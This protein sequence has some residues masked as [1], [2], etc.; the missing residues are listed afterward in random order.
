MP[1]QRFFVTLLALVALLLPRLAWAATYSATPEPYN[2]L[3]TSGHS[4][5]KWGGGC[6]GAFASVDDDI[7]AE[8]PLGF[9]FTFG[10]MNYTTARIMSNGRLQFGNTYCGNG[11]AVTSPRSYPLDLPNANLVRT[12]RIYGADFD[13]A[14]G[15]SITYKSIGSA[16]NRQ[17]V[18]SWTNI[19]EWGVSGS[20]F[21]LQIILNEN[22]DFVYQFGAATNTSGGKAQIGWQLSTTDYAVHA[23][24]TI[25]GLANTALRWGV[26]RSELSGTVFEDVNYGGGAG[27]S[28][29]AS[30]GAVAGNATVELY[31]S[32]GKFIAATST[33]SKGAFRFPVTSAGTY[34]VRVASTTVRSTRSGS[35]NAVGVLTYRTT[36]LS[37]IAV[38]Q[39]D[40]VGG[41]NPAAQD[42]GTASSGAT[43]NTSTYAYSAGLSGTAQ[44]VSA[45]TA[46]LG[47]NVPGLDFGFNFTTIT[48]TNDSGAGSLRQ[49]I[50]NANAL[51]DDSTLAV[52]GRTAGVEH[53]IF[54]LGNGSSAPGLRSSVNLFSG[55]VATL[56]PRSSLPPISRALVIDAQRQ[57]GWTGAPVVQISGS[58]AGAGVDGLTITSP[59]GS[60]VRGLV[61]NGFSRFGLTLEAGSGHRVA[62][63]HVGTNAAGDAAVGNGTVGVNV[64]RAGGST[65]GG[66]AAADRN[67]LS[68]NGN[69]GVVI[70][71]TGGTGNVVQGN[72]IGVNAAGSGKLGN[73][74]QGI[75][76]ASA[77]NQFIGNVISGNTWENL[78]LDSGASGSLVTGNTIGLDVTGTFALANGSAGLRVLSAGNVIGGHTAA[79]RNVIAGN[80]SDG[81][82]VVGASATGN[83]LQGNHIGVDAAGTAVVPNGSAGV[84]LQADASGNTVGGAG[85]GNLIRGNKGPGVVLTG[86]GS[87]RISRNAIWGNGQIGIDLADNGVSVN[88]GAKTS[89]QPNQLMDQPVLTAAR[90]RGNQLAVTGHVGSA[91]GQSLFAG[92]SVEVFTSDASGNGH[93][94]GQ[95][96]L[97]TL[98]AD[99]NGNFQ[100]TLTMPVA[101]LALG[102]RLTA[103][104]TDGSGNSSEFGPN[105]SNLVVDFVVDTTADDA[106]Q[107]PGDGQCL[108]AAG[109]C[110]LRAAITELN[111]WA[112]LASTP[113]VAFALPGC[114][115]AGQPACSIAPVTA[116]P[117]VARAMT[118]DGRTQPGWNGSTATPLVELNGATAPANAIGLVVNTGGFT[119]R[120]LVVNRWGS[121]GLSLG[122][123]GNTVAGN[124][125]GVAATGS[126]AAGNGGNGIDV[127]GTGHQVGG[128]TLADR[129]VAS[130]NGGS[131]IALKGSGN[132][133]TGNVAGLLPDGLG[134]AGN[135]GDGIYASAANQTIGGSAGKGNV[136]SANKV[137]GIRL[138][139]G[140]DNT[141]IQGNCI[142]VAADCSTPRGNLTASG[143][144]LLGG[145]GT[146]ITGNVI[147]HSGLSG[148]GFG[149]VIQQVSILGNSIYAN[150]GE[151]IRLNI[152]DLNDGVYNNAQ[153][154]RGMD[155]P[156][157]TGAGIDATGTAMTV[158]G[159]VGTGNG[160]AAFAGARV[161]FFRAAPDASGYGEG[162]AYLGAL[163]ADENGRF[164]GTFTLAAGQAVVGDAITA[165]ATD[166]SGNTSEFGPTWVT[167]PVDALTAA[168]FN[169]FDT[170]TPLAAL[171][172]V[173]RSKVAGRPMS[174][175]VVALDSTGLK[176]HPGF[177]GTVSLSWLD[178]RNDSGTTTGSCRSSWVGLGAAGTAAFSASSR[179]T[180]SVTPPASGTRVMRL[181]MSYSR[182]GSTIEA[183]SSDAFAALPASLSLVASDSHASAAGTSRTLDNTGASGGVVHQAGR[184]FTVTAQALDATG[185]L[186]TG[187]TGTPTLASTGCLLP[188]GCSAG[189]LASTASTAVAGVY[190]NPSVSYAEVGAI[191]VQ[192]TD[193]D[194]G[195]IDSSDTP[196][197]ARTVQSAAVPVGRFVPDRLELTVST[198]GS[199]ATAN[200]ACLAAGQG[201]TFVGQGFGWAVAP[202]VT[203]TAR[204]AGGGVATLWTGAL[205]KLSAAAQLPGMVAAA[206]GSATAAA[207][208]GPLTLSDLGGG[209]ARLNAS[210][211]DR[212]L[213]DLPAG[214]VQASVTPVW[215]WSL[216]VTDASEAGVGGNPQLSASATQAAVPFDRGAL[217]HSGRLALSAGHGDARAGVRSL[218][219]LQRWTSAGWVTM[220]EDRGCVTV[221]PQQ[222]G[223][224]LPSGVFSTRGDCAAPLA[225]AAT[226]R[227]G[228]A[229]LSLPATP[230][231]APGRL[232]LRLAGPAATGH[233][234]TAGGEPDALQTL[235]V[236]WLLGGSG[237]AG[238]LALL[239]WG[240][241][242]RDVVLRRETW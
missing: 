126:T 118:I 111:T 93:G 133:V 140:A 235:A 178:A 102:A 225:A 192:L 108:T 175:A 25:A 45:V 209:Q 193:A 89:G 176:L 136:A 183:C 222:V 217:F 38:A 121:H 156:V 168:S 242:Q 161:E 202:Q 231:A 94:G 165:T 13:P 169:A 113:T 51:D 6:S 68:G 39:T 152:A 147:A 31:G 84:R 200:G 46:T 139:V 186:M 150:A 122:G 210:S 28:L 158:F 27:R 71:G 47:R 105:F 64:W 220:T 204:N 106:D 198:S 116:L 128:S 120:G 48:N 214:S 32:S 10:G 91:A 8:L 112:S 182:S 232:A 144:G 196:A 154:N 146:R 12:L 129:N 213:L 75:Y 184:P 177:T 123:S 145:T 15:G 237:G 215:T 171:S 87:N 42:P 67:V 181:K 153:A 59:T 166:S 143:V 76:A 82:Q 164:S 107:T 151:G 188:V 61:I 206:T 227:G 80:G 21:N 85:A 53:A 52:E 63:N 170:D 233:S 2:W 173:I 148:V 135:G 4:P 7:T 103:T 101:S 18:V 174:L 137:S 54:M 9:T 78:L 127:T 167:T 23:Y 3:S 50:S 74:A 219:Q 41:T 228:R 14:L 149:T 77:G 203:V 73:G 114:S 195:A 100:G 16:P 157:V 223:V 69:S 180:V 190:T 90:V 34:H 24:S 212:F 40:H 49:V 130:G 96:W 30:A 230:G 179:V 65:I 5:A 163:T 234:C 37:G 95:A 236:P 58:G 162:Q 110:S 20:K 11:T 1:V 29:V 189:A 117:T 22:G 155:N 88:D 17:F 115:A 79:L 207:S 66:P 138:D 240:L 86:A 92:A 33:D 62:G 221:T 109:L 26:P 187:Y 44:A 60:T 216:A 125:F 70:G 141:V 43:F 229:W 98:T 239:T 211:T 57:P 185:A 134:T 226:T 35:G 72:H 55:G 132:T 142:G 81:V 124:W 119:L 241:P 218:L 197:A 194:Y 201:A 97:G 191:S 224:E 36:A 199:L 19:Q 83:L 104:A 159:Y 172:G 99:G 238:P 208:F 205:M 131:G 56:A 160:Q